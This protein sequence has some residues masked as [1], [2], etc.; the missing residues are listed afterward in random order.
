MNDLNTLLERAAGPTAAPV[1]AYAD[2]TRGHRALARTRRR[3][4]AVG[5]LGVHAQPL[6]ALLL[7]G[8]EIAFAPVG[9]AVSLER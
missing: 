7:V 4:S 3:R 2:L 9:V 1:D 5:L 6:A 8:L